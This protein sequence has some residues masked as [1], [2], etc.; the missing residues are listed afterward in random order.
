MWYTNSDLRF[1]LI[2]CNNFFASCEK[3]FRPDLEGKPVVVLSN[4]DGCVIARSQ[5]A[6]KIR[7]SMGEPAFKIAEVL[8]T[9]QV[10]VFSSNF[11][12][13][14]ELSNRVM[15]TIETV[16]GEVEQYSIDECFVPLAA[17]HIPNVVKIAFEIKKRVRQWIG[18]PVSIGIGQTRT[19]A[20]LACHFAKKDQGIFPLVSSTETLD[21][22]LATVPVAEI[23][24]IGARSAK[25]L[26]SNGIR[27]CAQLKYADDNWIRKTFSI[28]GL[29][30]VL[31][32]RGI[33]CID[34]ISVPVA[35]RKT[36]LTSRTFGQKIYDFKAMEGAIT[37]FV[38]R[39]AMRL[40]KGDLLAQG[41]G[42]HIRTS[43]FSDQFTSDSWQTQLARPTSDTSILLKSALLGLKKI[44]KSGVPYAKAG[45][46]LF[47]LSPAR[48][49]Q[50]N[51][52]DL[53]E[54]KRDFKR[55]AL[56]RSLDAINNRYGFGKI[57]YASE[58][59]SSPWQMRQEHLSPNYL[60]DWKGL[61]QAN[62][63]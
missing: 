29:H 23:W 48:I 8:K 18:I 61:A 4:N 44:F 50:G 36:I 10:Q 35:A 62:C 53:N 11:S 25:K 41:L 14:G 57:H 26:I 37:A 21:S 1:L 2:D 28:T 7:I 60:S 39:A 58:G 59:A 47:N 49:R 33:P 63:H 30:T 32:L 38:S 34:D 27:N 9:N 22:L 17:A 43:N 5:E 52:L 13:Y 19:L 16:V 42:L 45:I 12:L 55:E 56:M 3:V 46:L 51:L 24:G 15:S 54:L 6:K 20:K 31:E 40:R